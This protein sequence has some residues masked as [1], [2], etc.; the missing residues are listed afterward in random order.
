MRIPVLVITILFAVVLGGLVYTTSYTQQPPPMPMPPSQPLRYAFDIRGETQAVGDGFIYT[1]VHN[2]TMN[3]PTAIGVSFSESLLNN[4][5]DANTEYPLRFPEVVPHAPFDHFTLDWE[6]H[7]HYPEQFYGAPHFDFH[8]YLISPQTRA[9]MTGVGADIAREEK[10]PP[11]QFIP[12]GY[13]PAEP[14]VTL[15][16]LHW[17]RLDFPEFHGQP[18]TESFIYGSYNGRL[19]FIEPMITR[20]FFLTKPAPVTKVVYQPKAFQVSGYYPTRYAITYDATRHLYTVALEGL[21]Y[22]QASGT[23]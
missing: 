23:K 17:I 15:M 2:D 20:A 8:F 6:V 14:P 7:G 13:V 9:Q 22:R 11:A 5:P 1:W 3:R 21:V 19:A 16:G 18:F 12:Q 4:L 10:Q